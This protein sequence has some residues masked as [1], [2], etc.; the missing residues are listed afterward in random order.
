MK[1]QW[2]M[3]ALLSS[4]LIVGCSDRGTENARNYDEN[5][6]PAPAEP[7]QPA[8][9]EV[10]VDPYPR[11][12]DSAVRNDRVESNARA[13]TG[14]RRAPASP[15]VSTTPNRRN[16]ST[17]E[18]R[19][20]AFPEPDRRVAEN[21]PAPRNAEPPAAPLPEWR[22]L[23]IPAGTSLPLE[24]TTALSSESAQV[25][26]PVSARLRQ[27]VTIDGYTALPAGSVLT[28]T[29]TDVERA[30]RVKGR[31]HLA[32]KFNQVQVRGEREELVTNPVSFEGEASKGEDA[33]KIGAGAGI[34]AI[35]GGIAGG[36]KGAAKGGAIGAAAGTGAVLATRGKDV[37]VASGTD[38]TA[39]LAQPATVRVQIR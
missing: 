5:A 15:P 21:R 26:A 12:D 14:T 22:E 34:G 37:E 19:S 17:T 2:T 8:V 11:G 18:T 29:V 13:T 39:T 10:P 20:N 36:G 16:E 35:I 27:A 32:F 25:E 30:G 31:A 4:A 33:T 24:L 9:T 6:A 38:I 1:T 23:R 3:A 28:G 7:G